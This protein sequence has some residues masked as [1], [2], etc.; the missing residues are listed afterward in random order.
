MDL[1]I[2]ILYSLALLVIFI[3]SLSQLQLLLNYLKAK[4]QADTAEKFDLSDRTQIPLVTIQLP[5][6]NELYVV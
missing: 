3:Y 6:Y 1:A 5:L 4:K 2:L